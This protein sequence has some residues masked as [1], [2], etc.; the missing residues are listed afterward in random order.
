M[1][2]TRKRHTL[3]NVVVMTCGVC[4]TAPSPKHVVCKGT[5]LNTGWMVCHVPHNSLT[6]LQL[7]LQ[8]YKHLFVVNLEQMRRMEHDVEH[9][10][11][12]TCCTIND[13]PV[14]VDCQV[15]RQ[16]KTLDTRVHEI[17]NVQKLAFDLSNHIHVED[18]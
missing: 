8:N 17:Q 16:S 14:C 5:L 18:A 9:A 4:D 1:G 10:C 3:L 7:V 15:M 13:V 12:S 2:S 6:H 11:L